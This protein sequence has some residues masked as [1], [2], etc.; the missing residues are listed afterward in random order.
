MDQASGV[1]AWGRKGTRVRNY[2]AGTFRAVYIH[3]NRP[4]LGT[5]KR[6]YTS[7]YCNVFM[8]IKGTIMIYCWHVLTTSLWIWVKLPLFSPSDEKLKC[9]YF[10]IYCTFSATFRQ[11]TFTVSEL[12]ITGKSF[13]KREHD[14]SENINMDPFDS[15]L[16][17]VS[18]VRDFITGWS[19][20]WSKK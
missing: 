20:S 11:I 6:R 14:F 7:N 5:E 3:T 8:L 10:S 2:R 13:L 4:G 15:R 12:T 18:E 1:Q 16:G 9:F 17:M 19:Y